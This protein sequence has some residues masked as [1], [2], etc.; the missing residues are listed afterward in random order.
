MK[1]SIL[2]STLLAGLVASSGEV[3]ALNNPEP[4]SWEGFYAGIIGG[5]IDV[6]N[7]GTFP[8]DTFIPAGVTTSPPQ[9]LIAPALTS[10]L[11]TG[12]LTITSIFMDP[13]INV[14]A[15][16]VT[17]VIPGFTIHDNVDFSSNDES[18]FL[19]GAI[20]YD[21]QY[22]PL[23]LGGVFDLSGSNISNTA[24]IGV[25]S[26]KTELDWFA[27]GRV[28]VGIP[29]NRFLVYGSGG[30][31]WG[32]FDINALNIYA[33]F[34]GH[35][36]QVGWAAGAGAAYALQE[37]WVVDASYLHLGFGTVGLTSIFSS[38]TTNLSSDL[39]RIGIIYKV[40]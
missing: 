35:Y 34:S 39:W 13:N 4:F 14:V 37:S 23:L 20:G 1:K 5:G 33:P 17:Q 7:H 16:G 24:R 32:N 22:G 18:W 29:V 27:T 11:V 36:S 15:P 3:S 38:M 26:I 31:A 40:S 10:V 19:G 6:H 21:Q 2:S 28:R 9:T 25:T 8:R 12:T 30:M